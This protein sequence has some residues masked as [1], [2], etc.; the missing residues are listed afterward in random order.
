MTYRHAVLWIDQHEA[1]IFHVGDDT[2]DAAI[3]ESQHRHVRRHSDATRE[4]AHPADAQHYYHEVAR[5][6]EG[7]AEILVVGP[8]AAK[9]E[10]I[11]HVHKH[12]RGLE[13]KIIGVETVDHPTDG[14]LVAHARHYFRAADRMR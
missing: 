2:F 4:R 9:L 3:I 10:F 14:Q 8:G 13:P 5:A 11:K 12:D 1:K 6:L 7:V